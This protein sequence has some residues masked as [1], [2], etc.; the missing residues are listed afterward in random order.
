M[1]KTLKIAVLTSHTERQFSLGNTSFVHI[2]SM[3]PK[4][5]KDSFRDCMKGF[6][7]FFPTHLPRISSTV[8]SKFGHTG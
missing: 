4:L 2:V 8:M 6:K 3:L 7:K 1:H 5:L